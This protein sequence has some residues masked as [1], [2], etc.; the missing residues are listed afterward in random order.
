MRRPY[1]FDEGPNYYPASVSDIDKDIR[2][3]KHAR[4]QMIQEATSKPMDPKDEQLVSLAHEAGQ[5]EAYHRTY[6]ERAEKAE[7]SLKEV[8]ENFDSTTTDLDEWRNRA[9]VAE[10]EV[11]RLQ[12][13]INRSKAARKRK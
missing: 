7:K 5:N 11:S 10:A 3:L 2:E 8:S 9:K 12:T 6:R 1:D 13:F 4:Q